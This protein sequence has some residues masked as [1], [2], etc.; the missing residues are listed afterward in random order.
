M[1]LETAVH[2]VDAELG[3]GSEVT[4]VDADV[5]VDGLD[6]V[7]GPIMTGYTADPTWEFVPDGRVVALETSVRHAVRRLHL[8]TGSHGAGWIYRG[9][10][11]GG[12]DL[13]ITAPASD[14]YLWTWGRAPREVLTIEGDETLVDLVRDTVAS[15]T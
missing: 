2:R 1:A 10:E 12:A 13:R 3:A 5:A 11:N 15:A 8:G 14:L 6:E 7:L 4:P 9:G